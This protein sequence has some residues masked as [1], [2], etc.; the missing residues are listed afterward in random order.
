MGLVGGC[1]P[2]EVGSGL[3]LCGLASTHSNIVALFVVCP[4]G[5]FNVA[6][7]V[8]SNVRGRGGGH[9]RRRGLVLALRSELLETLSHAVGAGDAGVSHAQRGLPTYPGLAQQRVASS[10][11]NRKNVEKTFPG[12]PTLTRRPWNECVA[13]IGA[14]LACRCRGD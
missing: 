5:I 10:T 11:K 2:L 9:G 1:A 14:A 6:A 8:G 7:C 3:G 4:C 13:T 12:M